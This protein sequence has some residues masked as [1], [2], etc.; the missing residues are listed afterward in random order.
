MRTK[1]NIYLSASCVIIPLAVLSASLTVT[2]ACGIVPKSKRKITYRKI[3]DAAYC[4]STS[5][6]FKWPVDKAD[7]EYWSRWVKTKNVSFKLIA[8]SR[9]CCKHFSE[10]CFDNLYKY[11]LEC[12][13][14]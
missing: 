4:E 11:L 9:L 14:M 7:S 1:S 3:C 12:D 5:H 8:S 13:K 6:L 2:M 10:E